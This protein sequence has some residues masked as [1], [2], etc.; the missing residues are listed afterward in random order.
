MWGAKTFYFGDSISVGVKELPRAIAWYREKLGLRLTSSRS[1][2]YAAL[3]S[4]DN[5]DETGVA[6]VLIPPGEV[7]AKVEVHPILFT[8]KIEK[9]H[10]EFISRGITT[11]PIESDSAGNS[12]FRFQDV[13]GNTIEMC[14]EPG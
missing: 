7:K 11:G 14:T 9:T 3:L 4:F 12:L 8:K 6:L 1:E 13:D 2:D 5:K 10:E